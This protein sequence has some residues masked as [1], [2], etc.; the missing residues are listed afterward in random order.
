MVVTKSA[1]KEVA[2][3][4][5]VSSNFYPALEAQVIELIEDA[6]RRADSNGRATLMPH[7]L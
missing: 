5:R 4:F 6:K 2:G 3:D 7:D 1:V